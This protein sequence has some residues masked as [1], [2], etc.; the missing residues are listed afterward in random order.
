MEILKGYL[1]TIVLILVCFLASV[2]FSIIIKKK[3]NESNSREL[4][5]YMPTVWTSIGI[6]GT[7]FSIV[8]SLHT[9]KDFKDIPL[10]INNIS[11]AF[12]TSI[13]GISGS[14]V[15]SYIVKKTFAEED[16]YEEW[17]YENYVEDPK[18]Y[19]EEHAQADITSEMQLFSIYQNIE[20]MNKNVIELKKVLK[21]QTTLD[22]IQTF[23]TGVDTATGGQGKLIGGGIKNLSGLFTEQKMI[24]NNSQII[25]LR[26]SQVIQKQQL[27][28]W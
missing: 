5:S 20:E 9:Q 2:V 26:K 10:L 1:F 4:I 7:F 11:P 24:S 28:S 23:L 22:G 6:L 21:I 17:D 12:L 13:I 8:W 25:F 3:Y 15:T 27:K 14:I 18:K 16:D 19:T